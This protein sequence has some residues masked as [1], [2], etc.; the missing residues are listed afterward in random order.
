MILEGIVTTRNEDGGVNVAPMGPRVEPA[1][2]RFVLRPFRTSTTYRNLKALGEGVF[3]VT[4]DVVLLAR[5]AI[6][7]VD[8]APAE[9]A[10]LVRGGV[11]SGAC[12]FYEF[13]VT[14][15]DDR[16]DRVSFSCHT[17]YRKTIREFFGF[18]RA[19]HAVLETAILATRVHFFPTDQITPELE[20]HRVIVGKT[21]GPDETLA[22]Q[23]LQDYIISVARLR[24]PGRDGSACRPA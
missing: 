3:H 18:N 1:M 9:P 10:A 15:V 11:L 17:L 21:G 16:E 8:D 14:D 12:R 2:N 19:K 20:R 24:D 22:F 13:R 23:I 5:S 6:G 7:V 4:D